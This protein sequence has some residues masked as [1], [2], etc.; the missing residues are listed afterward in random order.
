MLNHHCCTFVVRNEKVAVDVRSV[1]DLEKMCVS[2][3]TANKALL[4]ELFQACGRKELQ[5]VVQSGLWLGA[6]LGLLQMAVS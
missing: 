1:W 4:V 5:F 2:A 6:T 3:L